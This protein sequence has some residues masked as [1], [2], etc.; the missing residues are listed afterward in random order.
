MVRESFYIGEL[1][2]RTGVSADTIRYWE[3]EGVLPEPRRS[4]AGYRLYGEA[5]VERLDFVRQAQGLGLTLEEIGEILTLVE[6]RGV[7][8]C[9]HVEAKLRERLTQVEERM[10]ELEVLRGRL[11]SALSRAEATPASEDCRCRIIEGGGEETPT[12]E[13]GGVGQP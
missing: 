6:E 9:A 2:E 5:S 7:D 12:I 1:A 13:I 3:D 11:R 4:D 10:H 8:P